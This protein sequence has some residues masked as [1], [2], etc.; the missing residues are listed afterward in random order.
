MQCG[1]K[2]VE[3]EI[4]DELSFINDVPSLKPASSM[5]TILY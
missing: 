2:Y 1:G 5:Y 4:E 3:I